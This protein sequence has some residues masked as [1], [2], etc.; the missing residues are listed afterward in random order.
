MPHNWLKWNNKEWT[1]IAEFFK[2]GAQS[3]KSMGKKFWGLVE[4]QVIEI[5][6]E[7]HRNVVTFAGSNWL[8]NGASKDTIASME[9][10]AADSSVT[11][12]N[13]GRADYDLYNL[14]Q[15]FSNLLF[16]F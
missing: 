7:D 9:R 15:I 14:F 4:W 3:L 5:K 8:G 2:L 13:C 12:L 11:L 10:P 6:S 16:F 1:N